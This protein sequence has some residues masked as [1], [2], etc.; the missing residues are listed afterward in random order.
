MNEAAPNPTVPIPTEPK[1]M[2]PK[3]TGPKLRLLAIDAGL[4]SV[5][6]SGAAA[7]AERHGVRVHD[8]AFLLRDV[9][10]PNLALLERLPREAPFGAYLAVD[11]STNEVV[12]TCAFVTGPIDGTTEI[13]YFTFPPYER[14]GIAGAM[15]RE[16]VTIA[17]AEGSVHTLC[18]HTLRGE[19]A[20]TRVLAHLGFANRGEI[21]HPE[22]GTVWRWELSLRS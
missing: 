9:L 19:S 16:L 15:A 5:A 22:D 2:L 8:A 13:A 14:R 1:S 12:G 18:A 6:Q 20:S 21:V 10:E 3:S 11:T 17:R 4:A 7:F